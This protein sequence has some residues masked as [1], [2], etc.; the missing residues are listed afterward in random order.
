MNQGQRVG[1]SNLEL[2]AAPTDREAWSGLKKDQIEPFWLDGGANC[3]AR[4]HS[5]THTHKLETARF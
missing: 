3:N 5:L 2:E 4:A 1:S